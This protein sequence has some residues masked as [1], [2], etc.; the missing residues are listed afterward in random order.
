MSRRRWLLSLFAAG[1]LIGAMTWLPA[2]IVSPLLPQSMTCA[3]FSGTVWR[4]SCE[5]FSIRN[6]RSGS[7]SWALGW[8]IDHP[9][10]IA[11]RWRWIK[12]QSAARGVWSGIGRRSASLRLDHLSIDLQTLRNA[13]PSDVLLGPIAA[14][15]GHVEGSALYVEFD[16]G[17]IS[18]LRGALA[19]T[20]AVWLQT[21]AAIGP[22]TAQFDGRDGVLRDVGGPLDARATL[23]IDEPGRFKAK[24]RLETRASNVVP[25][26]VRGFPLEAEIEGQF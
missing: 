24:V 5:G 19:V 18:A 23:V 12:D 7:L 11:L 15:S 4:G 3:S 17:R 16:A 6:S 2:R 13:L 10:G 8:S 25:S 21:G 1:A 9:A 20:R 14:L 22:F 26:L